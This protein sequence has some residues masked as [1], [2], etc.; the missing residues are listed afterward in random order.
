MKAT[1]EIT[2]QISG[3]FLLRNRVS[4]W[5]STIESCMFN[6]FRI[7]FPTKK[8]AIKALSDARKKFIL[9][10]DSYSYTRGYSLSYD[11]SRATILD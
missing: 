3:N 4:T 6:T 8:S 9:D 5:E 10:G 2:G 1:I 7:H 11:A